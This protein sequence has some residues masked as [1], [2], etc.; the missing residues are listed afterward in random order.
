MISDRLIVLLGAALLSGCAA[1]RFVVPPASV[2][3]ADSAQDKASSS[4]NSEAGKIAS[5]APEA[6]KLVV[7]R[8]ESA[9]RTVEKPIQSD[10]SL[11][12]PN[13]N[14]LSV[15]AEGMPLRDFLNYAFG[16]L[17][18]AP[19][20]VPNDLPGLD[21]PV[22]LN[23]SQA[24]SSRALYK[25][26]FELLASKGLAITEK[27]KVFFIAS[28]SG[29]SADN[30]P[31][32][33]GRS[34]SDVPDVPG[35]ILQ[36]IPLRFGSNQS[37][38]RTLKDVLQITATMD[39]AQGA[40][41]VTGE[42]PAILR[43]L[44][45]IKMFD[46]PALRSS[47]IGMISP[48]YVSNKEFIE[49][50]SSLLANDGIQV[51]SGT[52]S[53]VSLEQ[54]GA[55]VVFAASAELL[56]RVEFWTK[57]IDRAPQGPSQRYFVY[58][59]KSARASDI[60][61]ALSALIG[62]SV[63]AQGGNA[64]RDTRSALGESGASGGITSSNVMRR[65]AGS[66]GIDSRNSSTSIQGD[67]VRIS[68]DGRGNTLVFYTTGL[69][70]EALLPMVQRL[71][72]PPKQVVLEATIAEV[73]LTGEFSNGVEFALSGSQWRGGTNLGLPTGGATLTYIGDLSKQFQ[74]KLSANDGQVKILS[75]P[76]L[77]VRDGL[78]AS[79]SVGNDV[80]TVGATASDPLQSTRQ[81]TTVLYRKTGLKLTI[82]PNINAQDSVLLLIDQSITNT[83]PG[84]S[85]VQGAP[86][87]FE[88]SV[89]TEV[90]ARSGQTVLL[91]GLISESDSVTS[92]NMPG[93]SRLPLLGALFRSDSK[94]KEKTEL[95]L[96]ITPKIIES[97]EQSDA[98]M[99]RIQ[100]AM[101]YLALPQA[102][103]AK[104]SK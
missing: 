54:T 60:G 83:V 9:K 47:R 52:V 87:F 27:E 30:L 85:Q 14:S 80:P 26:V 75:R 49:Q 78:A 25:M 36:I 8:L 89:K 92:A 86:I 57:Q 48:T 67:G 29:R 93:F 22:T 15:S 98:V 55:V 17:L 41:F 102:G 51:G 35:K 84:S 95:V 68:V 38:D 91:A 69:R 43:A 20:V 88:R 32:G 58:R 62:G 50:L 23:A 2:A 6:P 24:I 70:Y 40:L 79:I 74:L 19:F 104:T 42:R 65:D 103:G 34:A 101:E 46:Q 77:V 63:S 4:V 12:F 39:Q 90:L 28:V 18:K 73:S 7:Q 44:D 94:K 82:A 81:L 99:E 11:R 59:P 37:I 53:F 45:I 33:F 13:N 66:S 10:F 3:V 64:S 100:G 61:E 96:M 21:Q 31:I 97:S 71:D 76:I 56:E 16:E 72:V 1:N 5:D